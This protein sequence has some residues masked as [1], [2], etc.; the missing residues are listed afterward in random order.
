VI[1]IN[2]YETAL[3]DKATIVNLHFVAFLASSLTPFLKLFQTSEPLIHVL[4]EKVN[5]LVRTLM[6]LFL[7]VDTVG[8][9]EGSALMAVKYDDDANW[10]QLKSVS[11]GAGTI[12]ALSAIV[13]EEEKKKIC[14]S[15][16]SCLIATVS[17]IQRRLPLSNPVIRDMQ[18]LHPMMRKS[19]QGKAAINRLCIYLTKVTKNDSFIDQVNA[20]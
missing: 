13:N 14:Q 19:E 11:L 9:K 17:Y 3:V 8:A 2:E 1:V 10:L 15:F 16:R 4:Y 5:E 6:L 18:C 20:E 7:K 12:A